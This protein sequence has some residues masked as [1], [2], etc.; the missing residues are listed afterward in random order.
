MRINFNEATKG[1][2]PFVKRIR[3]SN[4]N[5]IHQQN[6]IIEYFV[7]SHNS[8]LIKEELPKF[9]KEKNNIAESKYLS[10]VIK[11]DSIVEQILTQKDIPQSSWTVF[12]MGSNGYQYLLMIHGDHKESLVFSSDCYL[13]EFT[14]EEKVQVKEYFIN[15]YNNIIFK[16]GS[17]KQYLFKHPDFFNKVFDQIENFLTVTYHP[18]L[19]LKFVNI[20]WKKLNNF[21]KTQKLTLMT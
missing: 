16:N 3:S 4:G 7:I 15:Q 10:D 12:S 8:I 11:D 20:R 1:V 18:K 13:D 2:M 9:R 6:R 19:K 17:I 5:S 14:N 21:I